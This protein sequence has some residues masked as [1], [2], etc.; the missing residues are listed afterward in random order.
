MDQHGCVLTSG[1]VCASVSLP[2][3][4]PGAEAGCISPGNDPEYRGDL[5][6]GQQGAQAAVGPK[7][8]PGVSADVDQ[9]CSRH[10]QSGHSSASLWRAG[11]VG[12]KWGVDLET[13][14]ARSL[15]AGRRLR[16]SADRLSTL[17]VR[18]DSSFDV[19][20]GPR[21]RRSGSSAASACSSSGLLVPLTK[22][23]NRGYRRLACPVEGD[24]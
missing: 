23:P 13:S 17:L 6:D 9:L 3:P 1:G 21:P 7:T 22:A 24:T 20:P 14:P 16:V 2:Q 18:L 12:I 15:R 4:A 10:P 8:G 5:A 11:N 19:G